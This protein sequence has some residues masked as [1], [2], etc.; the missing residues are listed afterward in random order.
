MKKIVFLLAFIYSVYLPAQ[1]PPITTGTPVMLGLEG[2]GIRTFGKYISKE[3]ASVYVHVFGLPYNINPKLQIGGILPIK[4]IT[5][6]EAETNGGVADIVLFGKYQLYKRDGK[7]KTFRIL[8][9]LKQILPTGKR[10]GVP[11]LGSGLYQTYAG[12]VVGKISSK[13]GIYADAGYNF[14][15]GRASDNIAY[16]FSVSVPLL[17]QKYPQ[18]QLNVLLEWNG[19]YVIDPKLHS[20]FVS[21]GL[22]YILGRRILFE[23]SFQYP[24]LQKNITANKT[25]FMV[26]FGTRFIFN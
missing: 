6:H 9:Q 14:I 13:M 5:P 22:Q 26:L 1:G 8:G 24:V 16:N 20:L 23:T 15:Q 17:P 12:F 2:S 19:N 18:N 11:P 7:A 10:S 4:F 21:P 3:Q 25:K